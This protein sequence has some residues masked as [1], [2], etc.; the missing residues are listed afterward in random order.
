MVSAK[1]FAAATNIVVALH[2]VRDTDELRNVLARIPQSA[3]DILVVLNDPFVF[4]Y[5]KIIVDTVSRLRVP[6]IYGF[7]EFADDGGMISYG[8]NITETYRGAAG[9][10]DK[11]FRDAKPADL[12]VQL[13]TKYELVINLKTVKAF[14]LDIPPTL[15]ARADDV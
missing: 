9:Y 13:P 2:D 5:R 11:I 14:G 15:L 10:V 3:P 6:A 12:P 7:R 1:E 4:T 8:A